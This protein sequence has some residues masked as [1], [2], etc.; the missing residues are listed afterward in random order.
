MPTS[1]RILAACL[2]LATAIP[3]STPARSESIVIDFDSAPE[4]WGLQ[5]GNF[6]IQGFRFSPEW[7]V[8]II[9]FAN[10]NGEQA[11]PDYGA[12]W[13]S[14]GNEN[15]NYL[16]PT[17]CVVITQCVLLYVDRSG[18]AFS[19]LS[20]DHK[21]DWLAVRSSK[22]GTLQLFDNPTDYVSHVLGGS[23]WQD[24]EWLVFENYSAGDP[25]APIDNLAFAVVPLP[26]AGWL[27]CTGVVALG[28]RKRLRR[29]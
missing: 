23:E 5:E 9:D 12:G 6:S 26:A 29:Q 4:L 13:D 27:L 1:T 3:L 18:E 8:D 2:L 24:V 20:F 17:G 14:S 25:I 10:V 7:H 11:P 28:M 21:G 15:T 19:F 16:G 22:G